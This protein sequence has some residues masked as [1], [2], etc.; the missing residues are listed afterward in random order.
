MI[1]PLD[2]VVRAAKLSSIVL[3]ASTALLAA[4]RHDSDDGD[5]PFG[6][7]FAARVH[8]GFFEHIEERCRTRWADLFDHN[9][10]QRREAA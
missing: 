1:N 8:D 2:V 9:E 10:S 5:N 7:R 3:S 4:R 6:S